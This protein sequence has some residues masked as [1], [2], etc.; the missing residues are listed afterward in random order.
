[1]R[2]VLLCTALLIAG[3]PSIPL[4]ECVFDDVTFCAGQTLVEQRFNALLDRAGSKSCVD[5]QHVCPAKPQCAF[6]GCGVTGS[7]SGDWETVVIT[8]PRK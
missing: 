2:I 4:N 3:C 8:D 1:M 6:A 5:I 7:E